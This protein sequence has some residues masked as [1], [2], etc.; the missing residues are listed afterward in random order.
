MAK[1][2]LD[3]WI[4]TLTVAHPY[5]QIALS[6]NKEHGIDA[7]NSLDGPQERLLIEKSQS[8][9]VTCCMVPLCSIVEMTKL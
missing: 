9:G 1:T 7:Q 2:S 6:H 4:D 5:H 3:R 8:Q